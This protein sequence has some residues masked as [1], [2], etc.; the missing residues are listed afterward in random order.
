MKSF[1][2]AKKKQSPMMR[3][4]RRKYE[5][6]IGRGDISFPDP[7]EPE[8]ASPYKLKA[9]C[10]NSYTEERHADHEKMV[11]CANF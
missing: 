9:L 8:Q 2:R 4:T 7:V 3:D 11:G 1:K 6:M 10:W 5:L